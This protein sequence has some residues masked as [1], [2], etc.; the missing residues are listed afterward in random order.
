LTIGKDLI[1]RGISFVS[2]SKENPLT[3]VSL[4]YKPGTQLCQVSLYQAIGRLCGTAQPSLERKLYTTDDVYTNYTTFCKNRKEI[5]NSIKENDNKVT[6]E[7]IEDIVLWKSS[8]SVDRKALRLEKDMTFWA[9]TNDSD[10]EEDNTIDGVDLDKLAKWYT[11]K[12]T[13]VYQILN[14]LYKQKDS[15]SIEQLKAGIQYK[16]TGNQLSDNIDSGCSKK[17][18]YGKLWTYLSGNIKINQSIK[19]YIKDNLQ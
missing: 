16:G 8:R 13:V 5:L 4:I 15:V 1:A 14:Y 6:T 19:N 17:T 9:D 12:N 7:L 3:A 10:S 2:S 11:T 18:Q